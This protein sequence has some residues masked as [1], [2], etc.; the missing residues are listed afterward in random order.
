M[1]AI[2][3]P[4]QNVVL[5]LPGGTDANNLPAAHGVDNADEPMFETHWQPD[6]TERDAIAAGADILLW[7]WGTRH[8]PVGMATADP[9]GEVLALPSQH[10]TLAIGWF[11]I[12]LAQAGHLHGEDDDRL[13][14]D[15][16]QITAPEF[17]ELWTKAVHATVGEHQRMRADAAQLV[18]ELDAAAATDPRTNG[19]PDTGNVA[20]TPPDT[21]S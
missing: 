8:P 3:F 11:Y 17:L 21:P 14:D 10:I 5:T 7:V 1:K 6:P 16:R 13:L 18:A 15:E 19:A 12:T 4:A 2:P 20:D 9:A